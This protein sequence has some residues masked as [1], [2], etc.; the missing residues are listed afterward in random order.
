[1]KKNF[2]IRTKTIIIAL[3]MM[4]LSINYGYSQTNGDNFDFNLYTPGNYA[5]WRGYQAQTSS[6]TSTITF[7]AW[8]AFND[9]APCVW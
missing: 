8:T 1:M 9:P 6:T 3:L 5:G 2:I 7:S 4:F